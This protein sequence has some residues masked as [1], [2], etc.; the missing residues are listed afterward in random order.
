MME[1]LFPALRM[2]GRTIFW[3]SL[4]SVPLGAALGVLEILLG[5]GLLQVMRQFGLAAESGGMGLSFPGGPLTGLIMVSAAL[6][7][8][9]LLRYA[10]PWITVEMFGQRVRDH[11]MDRVLGDHRETVPLGMAEISNILSVLLPKGGKILDSVTQSV[12]SAIQI[13][14]LLAAMLYL[15]MRVTGLLLVSGFVLGLPVLLLRRTFQGFADRSRKEVERFTRLLVRNAQNV[16]FIKLCGMGRI[17]AEQMR[18]MSARGQHHFN[19]FTW[20]FA[21]S[22]ALPQ[23]SGVLLI[24]FMLVAND[25]RHFLS[26]A[27]LIPFT[28]MLWR[29]ASTAAQ[30]GSSSAQTNVAM[31][32]FVQL[33]DRLGPIVQAV[34]EPED[35]QGPAPVLRS[36]DVRGLIIGRER[37]LFSGLD[38]SVGAGDCLLIA[39][40]S[41][42]GKTTLLMT[43]L[44]LLLPHG[45]MVSWNH[46]PLD[47][48]PQAAFR[49]RIGYAGQDPFLFEGS[50]RDNL[51]YGNRQDIDDD[52]VHKA[53]GAARCGFVHD[54]AGGLDH[55]LSEDGGGISA[56][57]KQRLAIAR[58]LLRRPDV[59][60]F[61]EATANIDEATEAEI[62]A[63]IRR[64]FPTVMI[65]AVSHRASMR[66]FA[67]RVIEI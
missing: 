50:L 5:I 24:A 54:F 65:L 45:G 3:L 29:L 10:L 22:S 8:L 43:V 17:E 23:F 44:G 37:A 4:A 53:L 27:V 1:R 35:T 46:V 20:I 56:G 6:T 57:Q 19:Q 63:N 40:P 33:I 60:V 11:L 51:L 55:P 16:V 25:S 21:A 38:V 64:D 2:L 28:Y 59:L 15:D 34:P 42:R 48:F 52:A 66:T 26:P 32:F 47:D 7:V 9:R 12:A 13:T 36:L 41:G 14:A 61:D 30:L 62:M 31:P 58:A 18:A 49:S 67:T 39:G